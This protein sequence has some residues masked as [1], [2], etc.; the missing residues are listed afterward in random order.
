VVGSKAEASD[1]VKEREEHQLDGQE[2]AS[3]ETEEPA[4]KRT[5]KE[6]GHTMK[7]RSSTAKE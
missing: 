1:D 7:T 5:R 2:E 6:G 4:K 3:E